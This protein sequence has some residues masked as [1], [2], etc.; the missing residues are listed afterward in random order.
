MMTSTEIAHEADYQARHGNPQ[1]RDAHS[2]DGCIL[3]PP[4]MCFTCHAA[5]T[6]KGSIEC[7]Q[8]SIAAELRWVGYQRLA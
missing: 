7:L 4:G 1:P 8:C 2:F 6:I 3:P 5:P